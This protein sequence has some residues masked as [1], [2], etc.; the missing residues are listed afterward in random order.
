MILSRIYCQCPFQDD[1]LM[2]RWTLTY[3][4]VCLLLCQQSKTMA[5][6]VENILQNDLKV[7]A[8]SRNMLKA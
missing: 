8:C 4:N 6:T 5:N 2:K 3:A 7:T 1:R